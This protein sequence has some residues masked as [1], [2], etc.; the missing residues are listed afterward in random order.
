M[1]KINEL[2]CIKWQKR[3]F[4]SAFENNN[5]EYITKALTMT[6]AIIG[7]FCPIT[8]LINSFFNISLDIYKY[9]II[10]PVVFSV[11]LIYLIYTKYSKHIISPYI[12]QKNFISI[13]SIDEFVAEPK[14]FIQKLIGRT[15]EIK[16]LNSIIISEFDETINKRALCLTGESG[17][18]K[19]TIV[20]IFMEKYKNVYDFF[21]C[22]S[23]Y[24]TVLYKM[25]YDFS[26]ETYAEAIEEINAISQNRKI[27]FIFDQF[28][29]FFLIPK[30]KQIKF[31]NEFYNKL[32]MKNVAVLFTIKSNNLMD[33]M[34]SINLKIDSQN[35]LNNGVLYLFEKDK[36][37]L[38]PNSDSVE[39]PSNLLFLGYEKNKVQLENRHN[40]I[41]TL[42]DITFSE[43]ASNVYRFVEDSKIIEQQIVLNVFENEDDKTYIDK[44]MKNNSVN[45]IIMLYFER[46]LCSTGYH[47]EAMQIMY[48]LGLGRKNNLTFT[49][50]QIGAALFNCKEKN[51]IVYNCLKKLK[52][53]HLI[54]LTENDGNRYEIT[55][56][57]I[58]EKSVEYGNKE[59]NTESRSILEFYIDN[60]NNKIFIDHVS[61]LA[62]NKSK[63][64][65]ILNFA[66][67]AVNIFI[68]IRYIYHALYLGNVDYSICIP[69]AAVSSIV[70][71]YGLYVN[72]Y[73]LHSSKKRNIIHLI[74][75]IVIPCLCILIG[76]S[77]H[78]K[79]PYLCF[80]M[81]FFA[82]GF[83]VISLIVMNNIVK[84]AK[85]Y[86]RTFG[87]KFILVGCI[88]I[89]LSIVSMYSEINT[90]IQFL[91]Y[92][93]VVIYGYITQLNKRYYYYVLGMMSH[94][95]L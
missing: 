35:K 40:D 54:K 50:N 61:R 18:G 21:Y 60:F 24:E 89:V 13:Y 30:D 1:N 75:I 53:L 16:H 56:D 86:F 91:L 64:R 51:S 23:N 15:Y 8:E 31:I 5:R 6:W 3:I 49:A 10:I 62:Q 85:D 80:S 25:K 48:L 29:N 2:K 55:H 46:Q 93:I 37:L 77:P 7:M 66:F 78:I 26:A 34:S 58:A 20:N 32:T 11:I 72:A 19:S 45:Q 38:Y 44:L 94:L 88:I 63:R 59:L 41:R 68:I 69:I 36:Y 79:Y 27:V 17:T 92:M 82:I 90:Y 83:S 67:I 9:I 71:G 70:Y 95:Q 81:G 57:Y 42:C 65:D 12:R 28:E 22:C 87:L 33:L 47:F 52:E 73:G 14:K 74:L 84:I 4:P 39:I 43:N 76:T